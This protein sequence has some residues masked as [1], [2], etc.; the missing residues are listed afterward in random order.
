MKGFHNLFF[1]LIPLTA[2]GIL[3][4]GGSKNNPML[5][6]LSV[7]PASATAQNGQAQFTAT[8][9]FSNSMMTTNSVS[10]SWMQTP[11]V[12]DP[13]GTQMM[14]FMLTNQPFTA[15]C[16]GFHGNITVAAFAPVAGDAPANGSMPIGVFMDLAVNHT[17]TQED[18]FIAATAQMT[19]P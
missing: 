16:F 3:G 15:Q 19:C 8:G 9:Q 12:F 1:A 7:S 11:P 6:S 5:Q 17:M 4:C 2:F 13:P 10:V 14:P 18:G